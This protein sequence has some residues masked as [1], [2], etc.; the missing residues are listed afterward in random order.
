ME[1]LIAEI[2]GLI[3]AGLYILSYAILQY[4]RRFARTMAYS[5]LNLFASSLVLISVFYFWNSSSF[6]IQIFWIIISLFGV[7]KCLLVAHRKRNK[8][9]LKAASASLA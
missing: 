3:G 9:K 2:L 1:S 5:L 6:V 4:R 8:E 7:H